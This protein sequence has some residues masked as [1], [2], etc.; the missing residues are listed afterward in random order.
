MSSANNP[1]PAQHASYPS[2]PSIHTIDI[3]YFAKLGRILHEIGA[4]HLLSTFAD[5]GVND[6][7]LEELS[8]MS[9]ENLSR[10]YSMT[11]EIS[12]SFIQ[13]L[14]SCRCVC[15]RPSKCTH[16]PCISRRVP[17][18]SCARCGARARFR[19]SRRSSEHARQGC[20]TAQALCCTLQNWSAI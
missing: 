11:E 6:S 10:L 7:K 13:Q 1:Q 2:N 4:P 8:R 15:A 12:N 19:G 20:C 14:C 17:R 3:Y 16:S 9:P 18:C 5:V